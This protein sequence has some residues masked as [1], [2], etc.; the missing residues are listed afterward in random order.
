MTGSVKNPTV[1]DVPPGYE[2]AP[3]NSGFSQTVG[4]WYRVPAVDY[5]QFAFR[6]DERHINSIGIIHGGMMMSF[7]DTLLGQAHR[8]VS[9]RPAVTTRMTVDFIDAARFGDLVEGKGEVT[10]ITRN[11][12]FVR[13]TVW[14]G[15]RTLLNASGVFSFVRERG[16]GEE[17][18]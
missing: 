16:K 7:A 4:P 5:A 15:R 2:V 8:K 6:A 12:V 17:S 1:F 11:L 3:L 10:R 14:S 18:S 9:G 13:C